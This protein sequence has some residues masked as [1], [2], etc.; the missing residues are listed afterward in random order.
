MCPFRLRCKFEQKGASIMAYED[1][2][3]QTFGKLTVI[4]KAE[5]SGSGTRWLCRCECGNERIVFAS[6]L[7][8]GHTV[9]CGCAKEKD[10]TGKKFGMLTV[11]RRSD[12]RNPRGKRTTP[13]WECQCECGAITYKATDT[14]T[15]DE[16]NACFACAQKYAAEKAR[17]EAGFVAGTQITKLTVGGA[18]SNNASGF[19]GVYY[20]RK[21]G[22]WRARL[23]LK[24]KLMNFGSFYNIE[25][26]IE[27]RKKAEEEYFAPLVETFGKHD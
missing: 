24:G 18:E 6:N 15:N 4:E 10:L 14:L 9:S 7:K 8:C 2:T 16:Y 13:Q 23:R 25:D 12:K 26:A 22:K 27:A 1:L 11:I 19:R 5:S 20:D 21:T 17:A 3:G